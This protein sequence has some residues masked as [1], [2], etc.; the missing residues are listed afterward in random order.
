MKLLKE[1]GS[2]VK[3]GKKPRRYGIFECPKCSNETT[4]IISAV[5][6]G[7]IKQCYQCGRKSA[8]KKTTKHG[9][10]RSR[11]YKVWGSIKGRCLTG[12]HSSFKD[13]GGR[14]IHMDKAWEDY[15]I[16]KQWALSNGYTDQ[17][18][19]ERI[20]VNDGY[21]PYNCTFIPIE[22][23]AKNKRDSI[24]NRFSLQELQ[25]IKDERAKG[26]SVKILAIKYKLSERSVYKLLK[27]GYD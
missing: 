23:Q 14:G 10:S 3:N 6:S 1:L 9:D 13:Y 25:N 11:L 16:F 22:E 12:A 5:K 15:E 20:D 8:Q 21:Y 19:I 27:G 26:T 18:T 4:C 2:I 7:Y 17:L 24:L